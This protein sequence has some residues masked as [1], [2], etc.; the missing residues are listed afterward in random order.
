MHLEAGETTGATVR[1]T[2]LRWPHA[3][4]YSL[5]TDI[6]KLFTFMLFIMSE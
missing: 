6:S 3:L 2:V 5:V 1:E 4:R